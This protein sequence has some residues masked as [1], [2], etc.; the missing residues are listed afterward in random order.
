[1]AREGGG[2]ALEGSVSR[3]ALF[4]RYVMFLQSLKGSGHEFEFYVPIP[5]LQP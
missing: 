1:M 5:Y 2:L 3:R 4:V